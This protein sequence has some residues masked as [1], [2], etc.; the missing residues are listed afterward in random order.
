[1]EAACG[2]GALLPRARAAVVARGII[3]HSTRTLIGAE[4]S[5]TS[6]QQPVFA[7]RS[8]VAAR[9]LVST[10]R[11]AYETSKHSVSSI[12]GNLYAC[13]S[14]LEHGKASTEMVTLGFFTVSGAQWAPYAETPPLVPDIKFFAVPNAAAEACRNCVRTEARC[15]SLLPPWNAQCKRLI[16][17]LTT[18]QTNGC[19]VA[20]FLGATSLPE[21][22]P[23]APALAACASV[24][25]EQAAV[26]HGRG[27][28]RP[29]I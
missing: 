15:E 11:H 1:M 3:V 21:G 16:H 20:S 2:R 19:Q 7:R 4:L 18:A 12:A 8:H 14:S 24:C 22:T 29:Y 25:G 5:S 10:A 6:A 26:Q 28:I 9:L 13:S 17:G 27:Y 23:L